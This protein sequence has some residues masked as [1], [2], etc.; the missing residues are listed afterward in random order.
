MR[1]LTLILHSHAN[2]KSNDV[3][4]IAKA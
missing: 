4:P 3:R 2:L 1:F